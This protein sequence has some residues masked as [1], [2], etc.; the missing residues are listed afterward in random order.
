MSIMFSQKNTA[1]LA[2]GLMNTKRQRISDG[3]H[4]VRILGWHDRPQVDTKMDI[5]RDIRYAKTE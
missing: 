4:E 1:A 5:E 2:D 3:L